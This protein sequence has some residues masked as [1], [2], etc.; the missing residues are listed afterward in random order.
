MKE[1]GTKVNQMSETT[2]IMKEEWERVKK[3][4]SNWVWK[5]KGLE[6]ELQEE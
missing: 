2:R 1:F 3:L 6:E 5:E 4:V